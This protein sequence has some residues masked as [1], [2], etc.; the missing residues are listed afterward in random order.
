MA[1]IK[2]ITPIFIQ[3]PEGSLIERSKDTPNTKTERIKSIIKAGGPLREI[4]NDSGN[5]YPIV[6]VDSDSYIQEPIA[7]L[8]DV[9]E[10]LLNWCGDKGN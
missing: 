8:D 4:L 3:T 7:N 5:G 6:Y 10:R 2:V 9:L 1:S